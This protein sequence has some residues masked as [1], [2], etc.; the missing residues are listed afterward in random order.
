MEEIGE[1]NAGFS[2]VFHVV[3]GIV[4]LKLLSAAEIMAAVAIIA[5]M[6]TGAMMSVIIAV[7]AV[8]CG[9]YAHHNLKRRLIGG[10]RGKYRGL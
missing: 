7:P 6:I 10:L 9:M 5:L 2:R 8:A 1:G 4:I 3:D